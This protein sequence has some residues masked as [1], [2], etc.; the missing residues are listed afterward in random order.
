VLVAGISASLSLVIHAGN[1]AVAKTLS[2][3][4]PALARKLTIGERVLACVRAMF[5][6]SRAA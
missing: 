5:A 3:E 6:I 1:L 2:R 4:T